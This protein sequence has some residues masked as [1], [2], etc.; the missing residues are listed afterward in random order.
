MPDL[1]PEAPEA[2]NA[3]EVRALYQQLRAQNGARNGEYDLARQRYRGKHWDS[4]TN[5]VPSGKRYTLVANYL[6]PIVRRAVKDLL[7]RMPGIQ[8]VPPGADPESRGLAEAEE[9]VLYHAWELNDAE[10]VFRRVA[11]NMILLRRGYLTYW[12]DP[13]AKCVKFRSL[14]PDNVYPLYDGEDVAEI[15]VVSRRLTR[16]LKRSYPS[17]AAQ[18][19]SD[20]AS[21]G[22]V[23]TDLGLPSRTASGVTDALGTDGSGNPR[24]A[25]TGYTTVIDWYDRSDHWVRLMGDAVHTQTLGYGIG[26]VPVIEVPN[27][28][29]GDETEPSSEID[30]VTELNQYLDQLIS[31]QAD[32]IRKYAIPTVIDSGSGQDPNTIRSVVQGD[33]AVLPIRK[34]GDVSFLN[35][36]GP[37]PAIGEQVDRVQQAIFDLTRPASSYGQTVTNQSG[38][39]TNM[40]LTPTV[41]DSEDRSVIFGMGLIKLNTAI[42]RLYEKFMAGE[43]ISVSTVKSASGGKMVA[44]SGTLRGSDIAG[45]YKN[46]IK[47]PSMMRTDDPL[48]IQSLLSQVTSQPPTMSIYDF[49]EETG[50]SDV[51]A[52]LDRIKEE[53][54]DPRIHP[55]VLKTAIDAATAFSGAGGI[56]PEIAGLDGVSGASGGGP[57]GAP[58][59][60]T[61]GGAAVG[62]GNPNSAALSG[63]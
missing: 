42:L 20:Q 9:A 41:T 13:V 29:P 45:W 53:R 38:V 27:D 57:G 18:I 31:Q 26:R 10:V 25:L 12:W 7:A 3:V 14:A 28:L 40:A 33:G 58:S 30:D 32:V 63:Y 62:A 39:V 36:D 37:Q 19:T 49:L 48:F 43:E 55:E 34:D 8:V 59:A 23:E 35:W 24:P 60:G 15:I 1:M 61:L 52:R 50:R 46:V 44:A 47:W 17:L 54:E 6:R 21:D 11:H 16:E 22:Y 56:S 51:E 2:L 4:V 5:P